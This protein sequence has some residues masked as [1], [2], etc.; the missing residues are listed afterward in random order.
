[1]PDY[2]VRWEIDITADSPREA[3]KEAL[4]IQRDSQSIAMAFDVIDD[5]TSVTNYI[6][7]EDGI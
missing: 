7:L 1:M 5:A 2:V 4:E 3:A 6:D